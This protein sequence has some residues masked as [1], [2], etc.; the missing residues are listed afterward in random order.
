MTLLRDN[1][2]HLNKEKTASDHVEPVVIDELPEVRATLSV[3][4]YVDCPND[5][6][7]NYIDLLNE[8]DTDHHDHD[9]CGRLLRQMFPRNGSHDDFECTEVTC[10]ECK[11][12]FNVK[13]LEW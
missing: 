1:N 2:T 3:S 9:D 7:G 4:M 12:K 8:R 11:T 6:C 5:D 10:S 13:G